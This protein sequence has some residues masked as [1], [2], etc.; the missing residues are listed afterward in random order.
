M[1]SCKKL[2]RLT[3]NSE[4]KTNL[5]QHLHCK[6]YKYVCFSNDVIQRFAGTM[7]VKLNLKQFR[8]PRQKSL[9]KKKKKNIN[10]NPCILVKRLA[11]K[12]NSMDIVLNKVN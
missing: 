1:V 6:I 7:F 8:K 2:D 11:K 12:T 3:N 9:K 10:F 4:D 5:N